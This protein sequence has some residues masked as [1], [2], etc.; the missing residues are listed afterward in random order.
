MYKVVLHTSNVDLLRA[1]HNDGHNQLAIWLHR[2][3][4]STSDASHF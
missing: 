1:T 2:V 3:D 4:V